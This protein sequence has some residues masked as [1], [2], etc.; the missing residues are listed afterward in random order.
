VQPIPTPQHALPQQQAPTQPPIASPSAQQAAPGIRVSTG[1]FLPSGAAFV[2]PFSGLTL[3]TV[4]AS[5]Q[6]SRSLITGIRADTGEVAAW[7]E[8]LQRGEIG[9][10]APA[11]ANVA[12][13]DFLTAEVDAAGQ[14]TLLV[15]DAKTSTVGRFPTPE[16]SVPATWM[17]ELQAAIAPGRLNLG[18]PALE[19]A[20]RA[21]FAQGRVRIRQVNADYSPTGGGRITGF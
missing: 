7:R 15:N 12:G 20:I 8:A 4:S 11:G 5:A 3:G 1:A 2:D 17:S 16:S 18:D 9:L 19:A 21:A 10:Q 14:A 13:P 6:T